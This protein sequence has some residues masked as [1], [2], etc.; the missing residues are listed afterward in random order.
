MAISR[1]TALINLSQSVLMAGNL[2]II[3]WD[4]TPLTIPSIYMYAH[5][6]VYQSKSLFWLAIEDIVEFL[7]LW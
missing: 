1:Y 7:K 4:I 6:E 3:K 5:L 2:S